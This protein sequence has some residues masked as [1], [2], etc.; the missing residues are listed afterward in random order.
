VG[1]RQQETGVQELQELRGVKS[2]LGSGVAWRNTRPTAGAEAPSAI[3]L[4]SRYPPLCVLRCL[5][6]TFF[7]FIL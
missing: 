2:L 1:S 4:P 6:F 5:L 7:S 3:T